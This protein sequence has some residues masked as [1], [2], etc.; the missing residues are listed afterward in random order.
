[1]IPIRLR[2]SKASQ[3]PR[4]MDTAD[5]QPRKHTQCSAPIVL[6]IKQRLHHTSVHPKNTPRVGGNLYEVSKELYYYR[7]TAYM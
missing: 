7:Y 6:R 4:A 5:K 1:M 2:F 3:L